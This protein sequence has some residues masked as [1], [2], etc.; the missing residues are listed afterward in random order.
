MLRM[1]VIGLDEDA[2]AEL[3][4]LTVLSMPSF[5]N[6][7]VGEIS[8]DIFAYYARY[9]FP[10]P[11][12]EVELSDEQRLDGFLPVEHL[13][14]WHRDLL[15]A[16]L[17]AERMLAT[18]KRGGADNRLA[19]RACQALAARGPNRMIAVPASAT[20]PPITSQRSGRA[21]ST[22]HSHAIA[23]QI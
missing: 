22:A 7:I 6:M 11:R 4:A 13:Y 2:G 5:N 19:V 16:T 14:R 15:A 12:H 10:D 9:I 20:A 3:G 17:A 23:A 8:A 18:F 1:S 21:P